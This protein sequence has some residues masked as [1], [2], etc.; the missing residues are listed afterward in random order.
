MGCGSCNSCTGSCSGCSG[1]VRQ[2]TLTPAEVDLLWQ[3]S[4]TPFLPIA[5]EYDLK[6]PVY[7]EDTRYEPE[8]YGN[9][10]LALGQKGLIRIDFDI[11]L[12]NFDYAAYQK[13][14]MHGSAALTGAGQDIV[15]Q[16]E[17]ENLDLS[18]HFVC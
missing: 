17:I 3:F 10:L 18:F 2:L 16:L 13:Y 1:C 6:K 7:L 9:A 5:G 15:E 12:Q 14:P 8:V 4:Q 11:P